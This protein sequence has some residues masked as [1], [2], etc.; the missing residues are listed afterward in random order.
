VTA[1]LGISAFYHD[2]AAAL[3]VDGDIIA[4]AQEERFT[5]VKHD[6][7]FPQRAIDFCLS[8]AEI[9]GGRDAYV[10][11]GRALT[12][13]DIEACDIWIGLIEVGWCLFSEFLPA[14]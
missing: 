13:T 11:R 5:R 10:Q 3:V 2:S 4:A 1:I 7:S 12:K 14:R 6:H 8:Q 9:T